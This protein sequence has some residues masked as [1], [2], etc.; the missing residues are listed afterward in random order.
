MG[1]PLG[2]NVA[3]GAFVVGATGEF[4]VGATGELVVGAT[5][6]LV[7]APG[8]PGHP[9]SAGG[10]SDT[11]HATSRIQSML[12]LTLWFKS[13]RYS[14]PQPPAALSVAT[15]QGKLEYRIDDYAGRYLER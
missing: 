1:G 11:S 13:G 6:E 4:V 2:G 3:A 5:G 10:T 15:E 12:K 9:H 14:F 7:G 8:A